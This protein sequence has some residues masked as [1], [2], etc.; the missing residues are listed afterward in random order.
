MRAHA[1]YIITIDCGNSPGSREGDFTLRFIGEFPLFFPANQINT[2]QNVGLPFLPVQNKNFLIKNGSP[3]IALAK[4]EGPR[5][6]WTISR[7]W[8]NLLLTVKDGIST[9]PQVLVPIV[10]RSTS[11]QKSENQE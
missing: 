1:P 3:A 4:W 5:F 10:R 6:A 7:P 9:W 2:P 8:S 11:L